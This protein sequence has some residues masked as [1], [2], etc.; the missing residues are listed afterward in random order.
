M[1]TCYRTPFGVPV[2]LS[3]SLPGD[4]NLQNGTTI[5]PIMK[6]L[7]G[8]LLTFVLDAGNEVEFQEWG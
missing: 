2:A 7:T 3:L 6:G 4:V 5:L 1:S 8:R